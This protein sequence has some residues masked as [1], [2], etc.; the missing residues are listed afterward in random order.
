[1]RYDTQVIEANQLIVLPLSAFVL[2]VLLHSMAL[3]AFPAMHLMDFPERY[4]LK[5]KRIPYPTGIL[6]VLAFLLLFACIQT[7]LS[8]PWS[9]QHI[10]LM[11]GVALLALASFTDDRLSLSSRNRLAIQV[12][13]ALIIFGTGTRIFSLTNPLE[14][15][16]G[17]ERI[18]LDTLVLRSPLLSDPSLVGA[19][20]TVLWLGL[21]VN[22][23]NWFDGI[24]GQVS[25][26]ALIGFLTIGFLSL[27]ARVNQPELALLSFV[28]AGLAAGGLLFD[29]PPA[30]VLMGDSGAMFYGLML[31]VLTIYAGGKVATAFL[32]L[33]VPLIDF[34]IVVARRLAKRTP[35]MRGG[36]NNEHLHHRLLEKGWNERQVIALTAVLGGTFGISALFLTTVQK[37]AAALV[38]LLMMLGLSF[39]SK[40]R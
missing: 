21:T 1:M 6:T 9:Q 38:L 13:C 10:G 24:P 8:Q 5:R 19:A 23:L 20:F 14:T 33:G 34:G 39:Y 25:V 17:I 27:S 32:V 31:G 2:S 15:L 22:A 30:K 29:F 18:Q 3:R 28:L 7:L 40:I 16:T 35:V 12:L 4:G 37:F 26:L 36:A 11:A